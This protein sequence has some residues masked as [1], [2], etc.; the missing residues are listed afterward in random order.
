[1]IVNGLELAKSVSIRD[2]R[3]VNEVTGW[4]PGS[5]RAY[6]VLKYLYMYE[7]PVHDE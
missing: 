4:I 6:R 1:V 3:I 2:E 5:G 7:A